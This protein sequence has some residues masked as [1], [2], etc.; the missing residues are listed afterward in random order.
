[1]SENDNES[2]ISENSMPELD[3]CEFVYQH[4]DEYGEVYN[5]SYEE[6]YGEDSY[7]C[8]TDINYDS[9]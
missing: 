1:M 7:L 9:E 5:I 4:T 3:E 6:Y 2:I 8:S